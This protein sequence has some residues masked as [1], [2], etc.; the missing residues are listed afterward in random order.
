MRRAVPKSTKLRNVTDMAFN[1]MITFRIGLLL[2]G[3]LGMDMEGLGQSQRPNIIL[4]LADD[5]GANDIGCYGN[6]FVQTPHIDRMAAEGIRFTNA[7][8]TTS[9]CSPSRCSILSGRYPHNTGAAELHTPL[10]AAIPTFAELL[11]TAGYYTAHAGKW[12]MGEPAKRGFNLVQEHNKL[13]G[14]GGEALWVKTLRDRPKDAPFLM[15]FASYDAHR[16]W[17][18]ND[19]SGRHTP[20]QV[21][22]P[23]YLVDS[24]LTR[25]DLAAYYDEISRF[26]RSIG[27][28]EAE[29]ERQGVSDNTIIIVLSDNG[30]P[31]PRAKTRL[32]DSG[33]KT[34]FVV[35]WPAGI[36][37]RGAV[38]ESLLSTIDI[39][40]TLLKLADVDIGES[41]QGVS[42]S[43]IFNQPDLEVREY[44][45]AEHNWHDY[46][47]LER[48]VRTRDFLY[49]VNMRPG[50]AN[51]GPADAVGSPSFI[52][53]AEA[54]NAGVLTAAQADV[55]VTPRPREELYDYRSDPDQ[56]IN[57][58]ALPRYVDE[59]EQHRMIME[60]WRKET[61]DS[62]PDRL[63]ADWFDRETGKPLPADRIRGVMPGSD[64][65]ATHT[66][67]KGPH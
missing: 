28:V 9:S 34:P 63:T 60:R 4:F 40:P 33:V 57:I 32:Y 61:D 17:G 43:G 41:F 65:R 24:D 62:T 67:N 12:H 56:L 48:M 11:H 6:P 1:H 20:D 22:V 25:S 52:E 66:A 45:F 58:A 53:L 30:S 37:Y 64:N 8:V 39:A 35:K 55:F 50:L 36:S 59:L 18:P 27:Q 46:E 21:A 2:L 38:S 47:A 44:V 26:D 14:D 51:Q 10:P 31:F 49:V 7:Y 3:L 15:W 23:P 29:L 13:N 5:I 54:K 19:L 42:F 16:P